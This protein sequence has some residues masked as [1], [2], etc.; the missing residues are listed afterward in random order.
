MLAA[1]IEQWLSESKTTIVID[2]GEIEG[3]ASDSHRKEGEKEG[4]V[5]EPPV[6]DAAFEKRQIGEEVDIA[7]QGVRLKSGHGGLGSDTKARALL[8]KTETPAPS[9]CEASPDKPSEA[10]ASRS[11]RAS[12]D[13][14]SFREIRLGIRVS[15]Q[16]AS[17]RIG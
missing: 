10:S 15:T 3:D 12:V 1:H 9:V 5:R 6:Q 7:D 17:C 2:S 8:D 11:A 13:D 14:K 4:C 16:C